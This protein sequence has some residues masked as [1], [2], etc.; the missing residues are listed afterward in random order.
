MKPIIMQMI[1]PSARS[2]C[3]CKCIFYWMPND[4]NNNKFKDNRS[5][6]VHTTTRSSIYGASD[7]DVILDNDK[8]MTQ[9]KVF[10][11]PPESFAYNIRNLST[12]IL[13]F[14]EIPL[15]IFDA[16][17]MDFRDLR[18]DSSQCQSNLTLPV[19]FVCS[20]FYFEGV[21]YH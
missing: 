11:P 17:E 10:F 6:D 2:Q 12:R 15:G 18:L 14:P 4:T 3:R 19:T 7:V 21:F 16:F 1:Y 5:A 13:D 8:V 20:L 9:S